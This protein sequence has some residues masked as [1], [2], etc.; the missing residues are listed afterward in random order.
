MLLDM[1]GVPLWRFRR[2][3]SD[4]N[5]D[6]LICLTFQIRFEGGF[7]RDLKDYELEVEFRR[8]NSVLVYIS[9]LFTIF[10]THSLHSFGINRLRTLFLFEYLL[11][12]I[13]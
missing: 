3:R 11:L 8:T 1:I 13:L 10:P 9:L 4:D 6:Q 12:H 2:K 7:Q 5:F